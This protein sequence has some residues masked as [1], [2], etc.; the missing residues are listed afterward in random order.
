MGM[1]KEFILMKT[2]FDGG[3]M[4]KLE[5]SFAINFKNVSVK[6]SDGSMIKGKINIGDNYHR[7]SDMF[8][9][10]EDPFITVVSEETGDGPKRIFFINKTFIV[11]AG[12]ED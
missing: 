1:L 8:K 7:L 2:S 6:I 5:E 12:T 4:E 3:L 11:W 10:S 9:H